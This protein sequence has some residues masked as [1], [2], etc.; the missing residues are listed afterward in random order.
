MR[1]AIVG[2]SNCGKTTL[3]NALTNSC[4]KTG[5]W[6]G[7]TVDKAIKPLKN[8]KNIEIVDLSGLESF[9]TYSIEEK[10]SKDYL[11]NND[12]DLII[13]VIEISNIKNALK[14]TKELERCN[15]PILTFFNFYKE[16]V[17]NGGKIDPKLLKNAYSGQIILGDATS[18]KSVSEIISFIEK[19]DFKRIKIDYESVLSSVAVGDIKLSKLDKLLLNAKLSIFLYFCLILFTF[20]VAFGDYG[21]GKLLGV[22]I[23]KVIERILFFILSLFNKISVNPFLTGLVCEV[24]SAI[25]CVF[26]FVPQIAILQFLLICLEESGVIARIS[27]VTDNF[28]S[29]IGLNGK[30]IFAILMGFGCTAI[31][32]KL[33]SGLE[34][35]RVKSKTARCVSFIICSAKAPV[36]VFFTQIIFG[37][38]SFLV[39]F[40]AYL[41]SVF[42][43]ALFLW[44]DKK[45]KKEKSEPMLLIVPVL[46]KINA[47][48]CLKPLK[49]SIKEFII[50]LGTIITLVA[51]SIYLLKSVSVD[52]EFL[53]GENID[54]SILA[55]LGGKIK[56]IFYPI[57][58]NS[59]EIS[60]AILSGAFAKESII[61]TIQLLNNGK[62][63]LSAFQT[64]AIL[65]FILLYTPCVTALESYRIEFGVKFAF[66]I[67]F[68]QFV[69]ALICCYFTYYFLQYNLVKIITACA[70]FIKVFYEGIRCKKTRKIIKN[71]IKRV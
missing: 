56:Y 61:S 27:F 69:I 62:I 53:S 51:V 38:Y 9:S 12:I 10:R 20:Y 43:C 42:A 71:D 55:F 45:V 6:H 23:Q 30:S 11:L 65:V 13:N 15:L 34:N 8:N 57:K 48:T 49:K 68:F 32:V 26:A 25:G 46:R 2:N 66:K 18:S 59:W 14:L 70:V 64:I 63:F 24:I 52:F 41:F 35:E 33:T 17:S 7:V 58:V 54:R 1:V 37:K 36:I 5:N 40:F 22:G 50:K 47:K 29:K 16:F 44:I 60:T 67:A 39:L 21:L 31:S 28:L 4:E 19:V 3:F